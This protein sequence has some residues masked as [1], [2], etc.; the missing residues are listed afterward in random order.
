MYVR[1][2]ISKILVEFNFH[3]ET[4]ISDTSLPAE[5][6]FPTSFRRLSGRPV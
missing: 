4:E 1:N 5:M 2:D 3:Q 6:G